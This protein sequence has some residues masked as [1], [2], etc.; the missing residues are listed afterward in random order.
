VD[1]ERTVVNISSLYLLVAT[2]VM[3][4]CGSCS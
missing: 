4:V 1:C 2:L 3:V